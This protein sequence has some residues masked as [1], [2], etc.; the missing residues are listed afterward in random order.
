MLPYTKTVTAVVFAGEDN[1]VELPAPTNGV[2]ERL[3]IAEVG[4]SSDAFTAR[5][6]NSERPAGAGDSLSDVDD[7]A[8]LPDEAFAITPALSGV[9]GK[10]EKYEARWGYNSNELAHQG[11]RKSAMWLKITPAGSGEKTYAISYTILMPE[12]M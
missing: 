1:A 4:G 7:E 8:G 2:L 3:V 9:A 12:L 6:F 11:R 5:L 10:Y